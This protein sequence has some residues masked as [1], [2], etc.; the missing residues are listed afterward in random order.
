MNFWQD[1]RK[2]NNIVSKELLIALNEIDNKNIVDVDNL[3]QIS[4]H[5]IHSDVIKAWMILLSIDN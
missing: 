4:K 5:F 1:V 2:Y 3:I